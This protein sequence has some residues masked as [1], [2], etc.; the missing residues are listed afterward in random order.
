[1]WKEKELRTRS[2]W[3]RREKTMAEGKRAI[4]SSRAVRKH[5]DI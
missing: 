4:K 1:L 5:G 3:L 2:S